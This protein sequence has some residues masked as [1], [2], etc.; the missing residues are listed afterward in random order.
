MQID[1]E[2]DVIEVEGK[3]VL[4]DPDAEKIYILLN[5]L[6]GYLSAAS[7][8]YG[9]PTIMDLL[10]HTG[11]RLYPVGRLDKDTEGLLIVTN[12]G[13]LT[14]RLTHP[15]HHVDKVYLAWVEGMPDEESLDKFR[16][17]IMLEYGMTAPAIVEIENFYGNKTNSIY[18]HKKDFDRQGS[19]RFQTCHYNSST[20]LRITIHEGKKRQIKRMC[21]AIG[22]KVIKLRRIQLGP[23]TL[24]DLRPGEYRYLTSEEVKSLKSLGG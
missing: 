18:T 22:H 24:N 14:Y 23:I 19:D 7:D 4:Y 20:C 21:E 13:D 16:Q 1:P 5:K 8:S 9:V 15:K 12:D 3:R 11:K 2:S 17:G 6:P 10:P